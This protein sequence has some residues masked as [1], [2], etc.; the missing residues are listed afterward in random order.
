[1]NERQAILQAWQRA[2][3]RGERAVLATVCRVKGSAYRAPGAR[4]LLCSGAN[5]GVINGGCLDADLERRA[6]EVNQSG[7]AQLARYDTT[8]SQDIVFG[9]GLGCRGVVEILLEPVA[10]LDWLREGARVAVH[11]EGAPGAALGTFELPARSEYPLGIA[12]DGEPDE[13]PRLVKTLAGRALVERFLPVPRVLLFGAGADALPMRQAFELLGWD[14]EVLDV[15]ARHAG[16]KEHLPT[17]HLPLERL[18]AREVGGR[19]AVVVMTHNFLHDLEILRWALGSRAFYVGALGPRRRAGELLAALPQDGLLPGVCPGTRAL[20]RFH[21]P[22]GLNLGAETPGEIALS[23]AAEAQ[24]RLRGASGHSLRDCPGTIHGD[25]AH[26]DC[27]HGEHG[28]GEHALGLPGDSTRNL[29][30]E[31][32]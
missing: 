27:A 10:S 13:R 30:G 9:L 11:F 18:A 23:V 31:P 19:T 6:Q 16:R 28:H 20:E 15:R 32:V 21:A 2:Q 1:M 4:M 12:G 17:L 8:S 7:R 14:V 29:V 26:G 5:A 3:A 22:V 24:K 25:C